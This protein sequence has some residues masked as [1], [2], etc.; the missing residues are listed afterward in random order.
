[1]K[2]AT[3]GGYQGLGRQE[4]WEHN[5]S[6]E[7]ELTLWGTRTPGSD[8]PVKQMRGT[9]PGGL[10]RTWLMR[11]TGISL[12]LQQVG[13]QILK[14]RWW[15]VA[16]RWEQNPLCGLGM[17]RK[18]QD[19]KRALSPGSSHKPSIQ[20]Q[21]AARAFWVTG[22]LD[23]GGSCSQGKASWFERKGV[24]SFLVSL[25][26]S[27]RNAASRTGCPHGGSVG[28]SDPPHFTDSNGK[29]RLRAARKGA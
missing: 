21:G 2:A 26:S 28:G 9:V 25:L 27:N 24:L 8:K 20:P 14:P 11:P 17:E 16:G 4:A 1:M 23:Q 3:P 5:L 15:K 12:G 6:K 19:Q 18:S 13:S 7:T 10:G 22:W 29:L